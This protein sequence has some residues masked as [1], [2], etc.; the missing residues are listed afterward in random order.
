MANYQTAARAL[1]AAQREKTVSSFESSKTKFNATED[2]IDEGQKIRDQIRKQQK[3][4]KKAGITR[5]I[6]RGIS[7]AA[8][9]GI[10]AVSGGSLAPLAIKILGSVSSIGA[11]KL[12]EKYGKS[13]KELTKSDFKFH[14]NLI[15][16]SNDALKDWESD[17]HTS[18]L[19]SSLG[20][21]QTAGGISKLLSGG[22]E[23]TLAEKL[24][25]KKAPTDPMSVAGNYKPLEGSKLSERL[26]NSEAVKNKINDGTMGLFDLPGEKKIPSSSFPFVPL[27]ERNIPL[28]S[29]ES[30]LTRYSINNK[31][32]LMSDIGGW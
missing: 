1:G 32:S 24:F 22:S 17:L 16:E 30:E 2:I 19:L 6:A 29:F 20:D 15:R 14:Q 31:T 26:F 21:G 11:Q 28:P 23:G 9:I 12:A 18:Q 7:I 5:G 10:S 27:S 4:K 13:P 25:S 3:A 8:T